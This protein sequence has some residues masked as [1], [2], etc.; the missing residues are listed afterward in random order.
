MLSTID[1]I[2]ARQYRSSFRSPIATSA[3]ALI[4]IISLSAASVTKFWSVIINEAFIIL[5]VPKKNQCFH[6]WVAE[7]ILDY[8]NYPFKMN[9]R[10]FNDL[11]R[12]LVCLKAIIDRAPYDN[13]ICA[14]ITVY[15]KTQLR[16]APPLCSGTWLAQVN[17]YQARA[18][19]FREAR[20]AYVVYLAVSCGHN[21]LWLWTLVIIVI[22][23]R[24]VQWHDQ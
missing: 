16:F 19:T 11:I 15:Y 9:K 6:S 4:C 18:A 24:R 8:Q 21:C 14:I 10:T 20:Y 2:S 12:W 5:A 1:P 7:L 13:P 22:D 3:R 17:L 23:A